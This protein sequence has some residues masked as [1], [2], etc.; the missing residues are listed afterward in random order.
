MFFTL[1]LETTLSDS[2]C[3]I[4][5]TLSPTGPLWPHRD[6]RIEA[7]TGF[8]SHLVMILL[9]KRLSVPLLLR[10]LWSKVLCWFVIW[11][12]YRHRTVWKVWEEESDFSCLFLPLLM[13]F[14]MFLLGHSCLSQLRNCPYLVEYDWLK[15]LV[16]TVKKGTCL[17]P[18]KS[19]VSQLLTL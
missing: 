14:P 7:I 16:K 9:L 3:Q 8:L 18:M 10:P 13:K 4:I 6:E 5:K 1:V 11:R 17:S 2:S 12:Q 15:T 19:Q